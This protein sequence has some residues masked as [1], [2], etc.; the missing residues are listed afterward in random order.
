[1]IDF[2]YLWLFY[3]LKF[4]VN[5]FPN[6][7]LDGFA[8]FIGNL[9]FKIDKKYKKI[10]FANL[11][12]CFPEKSDDEKQQIV[13]KT[14]IHF[15]RVGIDFIKNQNTTKEKILNKVKFINEEVFANALKTN[16]PVIVQTAHYGNWELFSLAM[17]AKF[18]SVSIVGRALDSK[19]MDKIL[20]KNRTQFDINLIEKSSAAK[21]IMRSLKN[22]RPVGI[23][24]DQNTAKKD[25]IEVSFF[26]KR[27]LHTPVA[28]IFAQKMN[29]LVIPAFIYKNSDKKDEIYFF[30]AI[31]VA[32][33]N[34]ED[35]V[36]K[37]TQ[38]QADATQKII[39][40]K[41][42]EYFWFHKRFKHFYEEIYE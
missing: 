8:N 16:R 27:A 12:L 31:D 20:T 18:G 5:L 29:A 34:K 6:F 38:L 30:E 24:T 4:I 21:N 19:V 41:P 36:Q 10:I 9:A 2:I 17:A 11:N 26:G 22:N 15:A 25:G 7:M 32:N 39:E 23:L 33:F 40:F 42:D 14:Y 1:M 28:S 3:T 37:I 13:R 35:A